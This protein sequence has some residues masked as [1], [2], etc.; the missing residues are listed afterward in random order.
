M[1]KTAQIIDGK[2]ISAEIKEELKKKINE[3]FTV[4]D[5][6][7]LDERFSRPPC[8]AVILVGDDPASHYYV[9]SKEKSCEAVGIKSIKKIMAASI[10]KEELLQ[11]IVKFNKDEGIDGILLQLPLPEA[12]RPYTQ[13]IVDS[14]SV[15]KD[16][17][18]LTTA[19]LGR[20]LSNSKNAIQPCTPK[21]C[22][23]LLKRYEINCEGKKAL[24]LGRS[25]LVGLPISILLNQANA[26]VT[27]AHSRTANLEE[28]C[29]NA[30]IIVA[31]IGKPNYIQ[32]S[33]LKAGVVV[34]DVGINAIMALNEAGLEQRKIVGDVDF[35]SASE[36]ASF[37]TPVPG[38]VGLMTVAMLLSNTVDLYLRKL[39]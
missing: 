7:K 30:D 2:K 36:I 16:V 15:D 25:T 18:G 23:E 39:G 28:E 22:M 17:D 1:L 31:A 9:S 5:E 10:S 8:L 19:N 14:I 21:A 12:L 32:G 38:G 11:Q 6:N 37:I 26:T 33:W 35:N 29:K 34:I 4:S 3:F 27:M 20:L 13:E 24:V